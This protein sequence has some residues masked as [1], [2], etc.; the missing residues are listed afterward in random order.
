MWWKSK[1][2]WLDILALILVIIQYLQAN[3]DWKNAAFGE[4]LA[5]IIVTTIIGFIQ[6]GQNTTLKKKI[7]SLSKKSQ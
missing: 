1:W 5:L 3:P 4:G 6:N 7:E 2:F